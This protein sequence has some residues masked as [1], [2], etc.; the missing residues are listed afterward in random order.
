MTMYK[1]TLLELSK[2]VP[3]T[4]Q[5]N[6]LMKIYYSTE[7]DILKEYIHNFCKGLAVA[8]RY[9]K[10]KLPMKAQDA[11]S[12]NIPNKITL[13]NYC[14]QMVSTEKPEWQVLAERHGWTPPMNWNI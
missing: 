2:K 7:D 9:A 14:E 5:H 3:I 6:N 10:S 1:K 11:I 4:T 13:A 8:D 12:D